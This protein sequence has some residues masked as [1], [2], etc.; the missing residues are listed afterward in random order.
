MH[1]QAHPFE[2]TDWSAVE[3]KEHAGDTGSAFWRT[4]K[5]GD[6]RVRM[7]EYSP[8]YFA[9]HWCKKGHVLFC[10]EGEMETELEDGRTFIL[11]QGMTY[12]VGDNCEAHRSHTKSGC[13]LFIV[14]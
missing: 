9:N 5:I 4:L 11:K 10:Y 12:Q 7:V 14:D 1:I 13:K 2:T 8:G 3:K 6:I